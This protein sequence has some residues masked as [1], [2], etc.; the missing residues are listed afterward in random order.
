MAIT[1]VVLVDQTHEIDPVLLHSASLALNT[2]V[3]QDLPQYWSGISANV[4]YA[5]SLAAVPH[6]AWPVFLV[7]KLPPGEGGFHLDAHNQ[8][9]A[10]VIASSADTTWTI[11]ASHEIVEMLVDPWGNRTQKSQAIE[12]SGKGVKD[13]SGTFSYLVEACDPC[14]ANQFAYDIGGIAVSDFITPHYYDASETANT[15]YSFRNNISRPRELLD[16]GYISFTR[17]DGEVQQIVWVGTPEPV[18]RTLSLGTGVRSLRESFHEQMGAKLNDAKHETRR[19]P[20]T[21]PAALKQRVEDHRKRL[22]GQP[23]HEQVLT[24]RYQLQ[25]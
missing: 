22:G 4:S 5:P 10:K 12:I 24:A 3:V 13:A 23:A 15:R 2:Q 9:Y 7:K 8:P 19:D 18:L 1:Q 25:E 14:E 21:L 20:D 11:D 6:G 17:D 16:G